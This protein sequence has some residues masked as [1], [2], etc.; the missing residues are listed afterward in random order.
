MKKVIIDLD[1]PIDDDD[2]WLLL[3]RQT[4]NDRTLIC[5]YN[6]DAGHISVSVFHKYEQPN[7]LSKKSKLS[8]WGYMTH[9]IDHIQTAMEA[10]V[11]VNQFLDDIEKNNHWWEGNE[12]VPTNH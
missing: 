4:I 8:Q 11:I 6:P 12:K 9:F 5:W 1:D 10:T 7:A 2:G 3:E